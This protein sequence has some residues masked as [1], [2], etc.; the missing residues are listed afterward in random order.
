MKL[1][2]LFYAPIPDLAELDRRMGRIAELGY[3][4]VELSACH[5]PPYPAEE[6]MARPVSRL[7]NDPKHDS[8]ELIATLLE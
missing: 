3:Q 7:V 2:F 1:S 6:M 5:P 4:G 8:P